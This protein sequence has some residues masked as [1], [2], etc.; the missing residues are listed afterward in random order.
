M[1]FTSRNTGPFLGPRILDELGHLARLANSSDIGDAAALGDHCQVGAGAELGRAVVARAG[2][3]GLVAGLAE[4]LVVEHDDGEIVGLLGRHGGERAQAHHQVGVAG[5]HQ[6][7]L[8]GLR[9]GEAQPH[10]DRRAH[11][12]PQ[13]HVERP[14]A[15]LGDVPVRRAEACD[16]QQVVVGAVED[17]L[18]QRPA[19][20]SGSAHF[21]LLPEILDADQLL[22]QQHG[23][24][25]AAMEGRARRGVDRGLH[26]VGLVDRVEQHAHRLQHLGRA[27]AH[28]VLPGIELAIVAA[29]GD[30]G[31]ERKA[32]RLGEAHQVDGVADARAL[33]QQHRALAAQPGAGGE[34]D[35]FLLGGERHGADRVRAL[36]MLDQARMAGVGHV[37]DL[38]DVVRLQDVEN[39]VAPVGTCLGVHVSPVKTASAL[40]R[41]AFAC[42]TRSLIN[43]RRPDL[44][45]PWIEN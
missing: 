13:R 21:V 10:A 32:Q 40:A 18:H 41:I 28:R 7:A 22:A 44:P 30:Q 35:A 34:G 26:L 45:R 23:D 6:H 17:L 25:L 43:L 27:L 11:G 37:I 1:T 33:H 39:L 20:Q 12:A 38:L 5:D 31:Q 3:R 14:V 19:L 2:V 15:R 29:H 8:A 9:Q 16:D 24:R 4:L 36:A 42:R